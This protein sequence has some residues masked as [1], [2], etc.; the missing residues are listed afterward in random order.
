MNYLLYFISVTY[1]TFLDVESNLDE[2]RAAFALEKA[3]MG[4]ID[5]HKFNC[6][7]TVVANA[8]SA[9]ECTEHT[10]FDMIFWSRNMPDIS[11]SMISSI[12]KTVGSN[13]PI[14]EILEKDESSSSD[15]LDFFGYLKTPY[16]NQD[17]CGMIL[18][19][20]DLDL[21]SNKW[22]WRYS[23]CCSWWR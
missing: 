17:L 10:I 11:A 6:T 23:R 5:L 2:K 22:W 14:I 13:C 16:T 20:V 18:R 21:P 12:L 3:I 7:F 15:S 8:F 1:F 4:V 9:L 19:V